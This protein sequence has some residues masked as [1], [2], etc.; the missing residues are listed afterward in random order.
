M[1]HMALLRATF[2]SLLLTGC[3]LHE[4]IAEERDFQLELEETGLTPDPGMRVGTGLGLQL[5]TTLSFD[6]GLPEGLVIAPRNGT[7]PDIVRQPNRI[8]SAGQDLG[9]ASTMV[10]ITPQ[11]DGEETLHFSSDDT[12]ET[13]SMRYVAVT[14]DEVRYL[15]RDETDPLP[16]EFTAFSNFRLGLDV[17]WRAQGQ[18]VFGRL[19]IAVEGPEGFAMYKEDF[20]SSEERYEFVFIGPA[21]TTIRLAPP[22]PWLPLTVEIVDANAIAQLALMDGA[23]FTTQIGGTLRF[24]IKPLDATGATIRGFDN[25]MVVSAIEGTLT[26]GEVSAHSGEI[27]VRPTVAGSS[28]VTFQWGQATVAVAIEV[29]EPPPV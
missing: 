1:G 4:E 29:T 15:S 14:P 24:E 28:I 6:L 26:A 23:R 16:A 10:R 12:D 22:P 2:A 9:R 27:T 20:S 19:P 25:S 17:Q 8:D 3:W 5:H 13:T 7:A 11:I 21:P 18:R